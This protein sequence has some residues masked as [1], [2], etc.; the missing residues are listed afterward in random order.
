MSRGTIVAFLTLAAC[1]AFARAGDDPKTYEITWKERWTA[2]QVVTVTEHDASD[3]ESTMGGKTINAEHETLDATYVLRCD[4]IADKEEPAKRTLFVKSWKQ[5]VGKQV[6]ESLAGLRIEFEGAAW[7]LPEGKKAG[8]LAKKWLGK[9]FKKDSGDPLSKLAPPRL[10]IGKPWKPDP[11]AAAEA[12]AKSIDDAPFDPAKIEMEITLTSVEGAPPD[13]TGKFAL[14]FHLPISDKPAGLPEGAVV[15]PG[16]AAEMVGDR[17]GPLTTA[18][19]LGTEHMEMNMTM[20]VGVTTKGG[21]VE[22]T[23]KLKSVQ[24][25]KTVAGGEI[26]EAPA[27]APGAK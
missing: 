25:K 24:D 18:T 19:M 23:T 2:G 5:T 17:S 6:D 21:Q 26:P 1:G 3:T 10:E 7:S 16:S 13:E 27:A 11:K 14:K 8:P 12:F 20:N 22:F 15:L 9:K 4:A